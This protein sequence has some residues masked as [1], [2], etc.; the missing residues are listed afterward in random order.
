MWR[1]H[2]HP[3]QLRRIVAISGDT[4][5]PSFEPVSG[6]SLGMRAF[7]HHL[8]VPSLLAALAIACGGDSGNNEDTDCCIGPT[9]PA[10]AAATVE[11][12]ATPLP[13]ATP[14]AP[15]Q[16]GLQAYKV[17]A[18]S[19]PHDVAPAADGGVWYT[20][21]APASSAGST[22]RLAKSSRSRWAP[23]QRLTASSSARTAR[24]GSPTAASTPWSASTPPTHAVTTL[25]AALEP[26][27]T[28]TSTPP[29]STSRAASGSPARPASTASSTP[30][31]ATCRSGTRPNGRGPYGITATPAGEVYYASL[32]GS[33]IARI[34]VETG[35]ATVLEPPTGKPGR[36][37]RLVRL[38]RPHLGRRVERRPGRHVR[39]GGQRLE[40]MEAPGSSPRPTPSTSTKRTRSGSPTS[41]ATPSTASTPQRRS[42]R[43]TRCPARPATSASSSAAPAK[44]GAPNP[45]P[46]SSSSSGFSACDGLS[47][48]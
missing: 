9:S 17:P 33:H 15:R 29:P 37:P 35:E 36:P 38:P 4:L 5:A 48:R 22:P 8:L 45:P 16:L 31:T 20:A 32:A 46:T 43:P 6:V 1:V 10:A 2:R 18:G 26:T 19:R 41:A 23:A 30:R 11:V 13:S 7:P 24:P 28:P 44:S 27:P 39:R 47:P 40:G 34:N 12:P 25:P 3:G 21:R 42:S 14:G